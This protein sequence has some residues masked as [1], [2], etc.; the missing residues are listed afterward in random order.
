MVNTP[1][2][3][4]YAAAWEYDIRVIGV[5]GVAVRWDLPVFA[6]AGVFGFDVYP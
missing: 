4:T 5:L 1:K 6:V 2:P 3:N